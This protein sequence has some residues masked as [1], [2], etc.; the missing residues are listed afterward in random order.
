MIATDIDARALEVAKQNCSQHRVES[1][2]SWLHGNLLEPFFKKHIRFPGHENIIIVANLPYLKVAQWLTL[3]KD[4]KQF[5]PKH[6]LVG[7]V[8]GLDLYDI[9]FQQIKKYRDY[10]PDNTQ[11]IIEIDPSQFRNAPAL[12]QEYFPHTILRVENDLA[13]RARMVVA[14]I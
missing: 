14:K 13:G 4:V 3:T 12:I 6:A 9:L 5:E 2:V 7:G 11:V 8:D 10:F 1:A